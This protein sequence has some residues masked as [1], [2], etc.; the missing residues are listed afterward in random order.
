M[1]QQQI[2][3]GVLGLAILV[4]TGI[5]LPLRTGL[6]L[7]SHFRLRFSTYI[8]LLTLLKLDVDF[9]TSLD[10]FIVFATTAFMAYRA[11][12]ITKLISK[13]VTCASLVGINVWLAS[14]YLLMGLGIFPRLYS[15]YGQLSVEPARYITW[16]VIVPILCHLASDITS[17]NKDMTWYLKITLLLRI[18]SLIFF[19]FSRISYISLISM[20]FGQLSPNSTL[21][22]T[23]ELATISLVLYGLNRLFHQLTEEERM[24]DKASTFLARSMV[25]IGLFVIQATWSKCS[26]IPYTVY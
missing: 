7:G 22:L 13:K 8:N 14:C 15:S 23:I 4:F 5:L 11:F 6:A 21:L 10:S 20:F 9:F 12:R 24:M 17:N 16:L 3:L 26:P 1:T 25:L 18:A 2:F 19:R